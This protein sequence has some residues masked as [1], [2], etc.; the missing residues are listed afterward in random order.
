MTKAEMMNTIKELKEFR[1]EDFQIKGINYEIDC[2]AEGLY[3]RI[4]WD[5]D[6]GE[7][8]KWQ[9]IVVVTPDKVMITEWNDI[10]AQCFT[11]TRGIEI[12][13]K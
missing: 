9:I 12:I 3:T 10:D 6:D 2:V 4:M 8:Y 7:I 11:Y 5:Y 13:E 1:T